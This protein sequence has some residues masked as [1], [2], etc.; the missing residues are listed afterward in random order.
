MSNNLKTYH[1]LDLGNGH[2]DMSVTAF[3]GGTYGYSVQ[4][5]IGDKYCALAENQAR[6][7][8]S[9]LQK[10]VRSVYKYKA[11]SCDLGEFVSPSV[12]EEGERREN[13]PRKFNQKK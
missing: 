13:D 8:I 3:V 6:D 11:T 5:T 10:R 2:N 12:K 4:F 1:S 9:T 7:L